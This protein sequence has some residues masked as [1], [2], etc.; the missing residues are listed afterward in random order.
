MNSSLIFDGLS[1]IKSSSLNP[2]LPEG[3]SKL[4]VMITD[5]AIIRSLTLGM[6]F[7]TLGIVSKT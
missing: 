1:W 3:Q 4:T 2:F 7:I 6:R 5:F